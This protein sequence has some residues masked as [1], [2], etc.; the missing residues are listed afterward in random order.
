M[1]EAE[2]LGSSLKTHSRATRKEGIVGKQA[3]GDQRGRIRQFVSSTPR[4]W[5]P[6]PTRTVFCVCVGSPSNRPGCVGEKITSR[7]GQSSP[8]HA[9]QLLFTLHL[10]HS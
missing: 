9:T 10:F 7:S 1:A 5:T 6:W 8:C 2:N 3:V 4:A